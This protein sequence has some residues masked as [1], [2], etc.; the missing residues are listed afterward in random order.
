MGAKK[1]LVVDDEPAIAELLK[2][3]LDANGFEVLTASGGRDCLAKI[4]GFMP[5]LM[6]LDVS[7]PDMSGGEVAN[8]L[9]HEAKFQGLP[10][11]FLTGLL[12]RV[13]EVRTGND[14]ANHVIFAKPLSL[15]KLVEKINEML[16][17][18]APST[19]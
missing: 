17:G 2:I 1:I 9:K 15:K 10:I 12:S 16:G 6:V 19:T 13:D 8:A 5:D 3:E 4:H 18:N 14:I 7:M 11:I